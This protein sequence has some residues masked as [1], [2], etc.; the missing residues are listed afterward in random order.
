[1]KMEKIYLHSLGCPKNL[2]DSENMLGIL[3]NKNYEIVD[4]ADEANFIIINTCSFINDAKEESIDAIFDAVNIKKN[5]EVVIIVTGCLSQ[6][7]G[8]ELRKEIPEIDILVGTLGYDEIDEIIKNYKEKHS[9]YF[10]FDLT[11]KPKESIP[12]L[13]LTPKHYA[14]IK[15]AEGCN[16]KCTY[17]IIPKLRGRYRSRLIEDVVDEAKLLAKNGVKELILIAQDTSK[18]GIDLYKE[19]KLHELIKQISKIDGIRWIRVHYLYPEDFYDELIIEFKNNVKLLKYFDIPLQHI[20]N[21]I[22]NKMNRK[23]SKDEIVNIINK[24]R[25]E[26]KNAIIRTSI[27][28][29]FPNETDEEHEELK[30]F[31]SEMKLDKVG[32]FKFSREED[33]PAY[34]FD[35]QI[36]EEI[37]ESRKN[38]LMEIQ[39]QISTNLSNSKVGN[40]YEV[41]I[42]EKIEDGLYVGRSYMDSPEIDGCIYINTKNDI[43]IGEYYFVKIVDALEYDLIGELI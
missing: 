38:E 4:F 17:C 28:S 32:V 7:Y 40:E 8:E 10:G 5:K 31:L 14:F 24:I 6:R 18:Y 22:L 29:G 34:N 13:S 15:I 41:L 39:Q 20:N 19:K 11:K 26:V 30:N 23:I 12:R 42:D 3:N 43:S 35:N 16:N 2:V 37:K 9:N 33:T 1:M 27:I 25:A 21:N 36:A